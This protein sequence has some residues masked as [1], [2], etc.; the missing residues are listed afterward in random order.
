M[1]PRFPRRS[2]CRRRKNRRAPGRKLDGGKC[3]NHRYE[4]AKKAALAQM[5][6]E[7]EQS[8]A[9][10][11][12]GR[13]HGSSVI[14]PLPARRSEPLDRRPRGT[15]MPQC[16]HDRQMTRVFGSPRPGPH[17][18]AYFV[19][20]TRRR[21]RGDRPSPRRSRGNRRSRRGSVCGQDRGDRRSRG[22]SF[23]AGKTQPRQQ[24][25]D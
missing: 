25:W 6:A 23:G 8:I 15:R 9:H 22:D 16:P 11:D 5:R 3:R 19:R 10:Y 7:T 2:R 13:G 12:Y 24:P 4:A 17:G 21:L 14:I 18:V 1:P 20:R